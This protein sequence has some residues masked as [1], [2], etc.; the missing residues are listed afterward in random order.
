MRGQRFFHGPEYGYGV[1]VVVLKASMAEDV[2]PILATN[3]HGGALAQRIVACLN[4]L[5]GIPTEHLTP[6]P[7]KDPLFTH[8]MLEQLRDFYDRGGLDAIPDVCGIELRMTATL[9]HVQSFGRK[10]PG[11]SLS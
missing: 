4:A 7:T 10:L 2:A 3:A 11:D 5:D 8:T 1:D 6:N 9:M